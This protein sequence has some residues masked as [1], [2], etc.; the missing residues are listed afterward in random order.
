MHQHTQK[1]LETVVCDAMRICGIV[2]DSKVLKGTKKQYENNRA[3][4]A[5]L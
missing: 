2:K 4:S 1:I 5:L 3:D